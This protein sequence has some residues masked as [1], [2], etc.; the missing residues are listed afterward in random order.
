MLL[1]LL[2]D[3]LAVQF[4]MRVP[5]N[6]YSFSTVTAAIVSE[7]PVGRTLL[8]WECLRRSLDYCKEI[9]VTSKSQPIAAAKRV[10]PSVLNADRRCLAGPGLGPTW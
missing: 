5:A 6:L 3:V 2:V 10:G 4:A 8:S 1:P 9:H 7:K